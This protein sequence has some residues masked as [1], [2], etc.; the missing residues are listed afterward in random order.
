M[1]SFLLR[2]CCPTHFAKTAK[3]MGHERFFF[4][5]SQAWSVGEVELKETGD[6]SP[7]TKGARHEP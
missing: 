3:W 7:E 4:K 5:R 2:S 1:N 6:V